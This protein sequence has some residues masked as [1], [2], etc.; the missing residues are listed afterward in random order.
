MVAKRV[1][2]RGDKSRPKKTKKPNNSPTK[3]EID[4][5]DPR[6][7]HFEF[8]N[9]FA[10]KVRKHTK[11]RLLSSV[12]HKP[13]IVLLG[14]GKQVPVP[15]LA[16]DLPARE[17]LASA[18]AEEV[19]LE[20]Q[21]Y[22]GSAG[23]FWLLTLLRS[24]NL[25]GDE[26]T[27]VR[28]KDLIN[29]TRRAVLREF[30]DFEAVIEVQACCNRNH[31]DG[32]K[33]HCWHLNVVAR[34]DGP[35]VEQT[36]RKRL[37]K[38]FGDHVGE[39]PAVHLQPLK[40]TPDD[41]RRVIFYALKAPGKSKTVYVSKDGSRTN[42]HESEKG[43]RYVRYGRLFEILSHIPLTSLVFGGGNGQ[44]ILGRAILSLKRWHEGRAKSS[45]FRR[46][47]DVAD[48][49]DVNRERYLGKRFKAPDFS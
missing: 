20:T 15:I 32:G 13:I 12:D 1:S 14:R 24:E 6:Q 38:V 44:F 41:I 2:P 42:M 28:L 23:G 48:Y 21:R 8:G 11:H 18:L 22:K 46:A 35:I 34:A 26:N 25:T 33:T 17:K 40:Q 30:A 4:K 29:V 45:Q 31:Q 19:I 5:A 43:D 37:E 10:S 16:T 7:K 36:V 9:C 3:V 49:W 39:M 27:F 47:V